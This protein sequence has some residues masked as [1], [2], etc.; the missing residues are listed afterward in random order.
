MRVKKGIYLIIVLII[1]LLGIPCFLL[2]YSWKTK[3]IKV[4]NDKRLPQVYLTGQMDTLWDVY[5]NPADVEFKVEWNGSSSKEYK[6]TAEFQGGST[7]WR[8]KNSYNIRLAEKLQLNSEWGA[9]KK[10]TL[11]ANW[12]DFSQ[13]RNIVS[14]R[15]FGQIVRSRE[16]HDR[17]EKA[18]NGGVVDGFPIELYIN[19]EYYGLY[20]LNIPKSKWMFGMDEVGKEAILFANEVRPASCKL[21]EPVKE[22]F[23]NGWKLKYCSTENTADGTQWVLDSFNEMIDFLNTADDDTFIENIRKYTDVERTIDAMLYTVFIDAFD[24][25]VHNINWITYDGQHWIPSPYDMEVTWGNFLNEMNDPLVVNLTPQEMLF[26]E[27]DELLS[28]ADEQTHDRMETYCWGNLLYRRVWQNFPVEI[29]ERYY[30]LRKRELSLEN[31][32]NQFSIFIDSIDK[33]YYAKEKVMWSDVDY[34]DSNDY[35]H[36][37]A[38]AR[39]RADVLDRYFEGMQTGVSP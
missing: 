18:P 35:E 11:K 34:H 8:P 15:I 2:L 7:L 4:R 21:E 19:E 1:L 26:G 22:D 23:S 16:K 3:T 37:I 9:H 10:Y 27:L 13:A 12:D 32:E 28:S 17:L 39:A 24:V 36:I 29:K 6:G 14:G 25:L 30:E 20:T 31:I 38:F 33:W 5:P